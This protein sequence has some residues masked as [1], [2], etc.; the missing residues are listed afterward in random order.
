VHFIQSVERS[1]TVP[2]Y[3]YGERGAG[4][5][6]SSTEQANSCQ[7]SLL[8]FLLEWCRFPATICWG[9]KPTVLVQSYTSRSRTQGSANTAVVKLAGTAVLICAAAAAAADPSQRHPGVRC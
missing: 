1:S 6:V 3:A 9:T 2:P 8:A 5:V 4:G 7:V